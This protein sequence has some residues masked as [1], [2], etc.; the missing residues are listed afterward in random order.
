MAAPWGLWGLWHHQLGGG[1]HQ[2]PA[3]N[4]LVGS[5]RALRGCA[6]QRLK[7]LQG[8]SSAGTSRATPAE[9]GAE[10]TREGGVGGQGQKIWLEASGRFFPKDD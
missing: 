2:L 1:P 7:A 4:L 10:G 6:S 8:G 9:H 3:D 5:R